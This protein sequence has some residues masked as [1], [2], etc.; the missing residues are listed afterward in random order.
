M[1]GGTQYQVLDP[2]HQYVVDKDEG[3]CCCRKWQL[4]GIPRTH[5]VSVIYYNK[6][7]VENYIDGCYKVSTYLNTY[8]HTLNPTHGRDSWPK[9]DQG[10]MIPPEPMNKRRGTKTMLRRR[11]LGEENR[12]FT[13]GKV[14]RKGVTMR[15]G[16]CGKVGHNKRFHG[17][18]QVT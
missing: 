9:S 1:S 16:I 17:R 6:D 3:N 14:S 12:G 7:K 2:D 11:E 5:A 18:Q 13:R 8:R 10:P 15:C 4:T